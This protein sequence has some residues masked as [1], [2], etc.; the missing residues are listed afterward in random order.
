MWRKFANA[1]RNMESLAAITARKEGRLRRWKIGHGATNPPG[2][3]G[4]SDRPPRFQRNLFWAIIADKDGSIWP[5]FSR[6]GSFSRMVS[7]IGT[8]YPGLGHG[9]STSECG[10]MVSGSRKSWRSEAQSA[11]GPNDHVFG[12]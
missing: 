6:D 2:F 12:S 11:S 4:D 5:V 1:V 7:E 8:P 10:W 3:S 9:K